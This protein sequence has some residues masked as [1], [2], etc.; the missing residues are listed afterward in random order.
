MEAM[1]FFIRDFGDDPIFIQIM[2]KLMLVFRGQG[3]LH[4]PAMLVASWTRWQ[5]NYLMGGM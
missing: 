2:L 5:L 1:T 4:R 3:L